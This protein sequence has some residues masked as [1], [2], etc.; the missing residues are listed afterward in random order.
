MIPLLYKDRRTTGKTVLRRAQLTQLH[1]LWVFDTLCRSHSLCYFLSGGTLLGAVRHGG[2]I[3]WDDDL[4][5]MMPREDYRRF[6]KIA[7]EELPRDV[8]LQIPADRPRATIAFAKLR[9]AYSFYCEAH[10]GY[11]TTEHNGIYID[12][13]QIEDVPNVGRR[14]RSLLKRLCCSAWFRQKY[15]LSKMTGAPFRIFFNALLYTVYY[16]AHRLIRIL[17]RALLFFFPAKH[18]TLVYECPF[19]TI[20]RKEVFE[21][22]L[23]IS[24]E[25]MIV[26]V[27]SGYDEYLQEQYGDWHWI[28]PPEMRPHHAK[29][30]LPMLAADTPWSMDYPKVVE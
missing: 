9:D 1:L 6:L 21:G 5:V 11:S 7:T 25:D 4:D 13:F 23:M 22:T 24:F 3:P 12:V 30:I 29:I 15:H 14:G 28:P 20:W 18:C 27:P 16:I 19:H 2:F 8:T 26:P 17:N 10:D